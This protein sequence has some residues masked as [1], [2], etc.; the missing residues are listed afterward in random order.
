MRNGREVGRVLATREYGWDT[1]LFLSLP[2]SLPPSLPFHR[3]PQH[4][5]HTPTTNATLH[6]NLNQLRRRESYPQ[7]L[8]QPSRWSRIPPSPLL[9]WFPFSVSGWVFRV[10]AIAM[11]DPA[12]TRIWDFE[13]VYFVL[14]KTSV[15]PIDTLGRFLLSIIWFWFDRLDWAK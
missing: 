7:P 4:D 1:C 11:L 3:P 14:M 8:L 2:S 6:P 12:S 13:K 9:F 10:G 15:A 5:S